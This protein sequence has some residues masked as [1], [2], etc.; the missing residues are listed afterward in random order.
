M[1]V[2][3]LL[4]LKVQLKGFFSHEAVYL[5]VLALLS[6]RLLFAP[7][8]VQVSQDGGSLVLCTSPAQLASASPTPTHKTYLPAY[9][10]LPQLRS[11]DQNVSPC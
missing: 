3:R 2:K 6:H 5:R 7:L 10:S 1:P 11:I 8:Y 9:L 4:T